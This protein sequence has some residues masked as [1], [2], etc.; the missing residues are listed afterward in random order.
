MVFFFDA[1]TTGFFAAAFLAG[2]VWAGAFLVD[3]G[4][5]AIESD[6]FM[7]GDMQRIRLSAALQ[8]IFSPIEISLDNIA[9]S[10][11]QPPDV[12]LAMQVSAGTNGTLE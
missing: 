12:V 9:R 7:V 6:S 1:V 11:S 10:L 5:V 3:A 8:G 2:A 4:R